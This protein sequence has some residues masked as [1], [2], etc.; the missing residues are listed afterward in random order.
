MKAK[1]I[2]CHVPS[3]NI[4]Q[5]LAFYKALFGSTDMARSLTDALQAYHMP[6]SNDGI[7]IQVVARANPQDAPCCYYAV[8]DIGA[9]VQALVAAGGRVVVS[10]GPVPIAAGA[11]N[12]YRQR[13]NAKNPQVAVT[14]TLGQHALV[15]DPDGNPVGL[16]QL[17]AH[18]HDHFKAGKPVV[19]DKD[20]ADEH[21]VAIQAG[22]KI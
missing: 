20:I 18:A 2:I 12:D 21:A 1:L 13:V 16:I 17:E 8:D 6:I 5:S 19:L 14:A 22:S 7:D 10:P 9:T 15:V 11:L 3:G 4:Q